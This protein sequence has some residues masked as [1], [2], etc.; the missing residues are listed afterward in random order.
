M[1]NEM[2]TASIHWGMALIKAGILAH[3]DELN[4]LDGAL[5]DG[6]LGV[7]LSRSVER[8]NTDPTSSNDIGLVLLEY[9][10]LFT[11]T[12]GS[13]YGTLIATGLMAAAKQTKGRTSVPWSEVSSLLGAAGAAMAARGKSQLGDK[14]VLDVIESARVATEMISDPKA[15]APAISHAVRSTIVKFRPLPFKQGRAR[16]FG[17]KGIGMEDPGM[18][19]FQRIVESL[20]PE[21]HTDRAP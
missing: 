13:T 1:S 6:D 21:N 15:L 14:T 12:A 18:I 17:D 2:T 10:K 3:A 20:S 19:A 7:T 8:F 11:G 9:A 4:A 16:I 5:G